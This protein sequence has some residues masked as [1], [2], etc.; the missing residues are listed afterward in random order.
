MFSYFFCFFP[1]FNLI[2]KTL[3]KIKYT[4]EEEVEEKN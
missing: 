4:Y 2:L 3:F 1:H